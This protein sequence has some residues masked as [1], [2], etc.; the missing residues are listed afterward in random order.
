VSCPY[1][2]LLS[3]LQ[4]ALEMVTK[5]DPWCCFTQDNILLPYL[6]MLLRNV[7]VYGC[8]LR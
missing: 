8:R 1:L 3:L 5:I 2:L 7:T 6:P 4:G